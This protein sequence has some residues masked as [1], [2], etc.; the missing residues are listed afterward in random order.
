MLHADWRSRHTD[1]EPV[2]VLQD[3]SGVEVPCASLVDKLPTSSAEK[4]VCLMLH[5]DTT[6]RADCN[7]QDSPKTEQS[8]QDSVI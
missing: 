4:Q 5:A 3:C 1:C 6:F 7:R 2:L 8:P